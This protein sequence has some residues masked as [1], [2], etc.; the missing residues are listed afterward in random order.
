MTV[1]REMRIPAWSSTKRGSRS[2]IRNEANYYLR[3]CRSDDPSVMGE[4]YGPFKGKH[5]E[6]MRRE[7]EK[8]VAPDFCLKIELTQDPAVAPTRH[9]SG[10]RPSR[11]RS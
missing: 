4:T 9:G 3:Q 6:M 8:K 2:S 11:G 5:L 1:E 7:L 10:T